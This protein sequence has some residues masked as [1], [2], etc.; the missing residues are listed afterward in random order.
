MFLLPPW[1]QRLF[2]KKRGEDERA[3]ASEVAG[4]MS[5][6][7]LRQKWQFAKVRFSGSEIILR[8]VVS[9]AT[10]FAAGFVS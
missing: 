7:H 8:T 2:K 1:L 6:E 5:S 4:C 3:F 9:S 10:A